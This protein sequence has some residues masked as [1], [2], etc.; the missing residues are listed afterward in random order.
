MLPDAD[1]FT[2]PPIP[3]QVTSLDGQHIDTSGAIW[4]IREAPEGGRLYPLNWS[5]LTSLQ[6]DG[7]SIYSPRAQHL[8]KLYLADGITRLKGGTVTGYFYTFSAFGRWLVTLNEKKWT[9][10]E[11][12]AYDESLARRYLDWC[13]QTYA[14]QGENASSLRTFIKWGVAR[15]YPDFT[16]EQYRVLRDMPIVSGT[17][18]HHT[19]FRHVTRGVLSSAEKQ[20]IIQALMAEKGRVHDRII[21]MLH[22]ELGLNPAASVRLL[23]QD[24][25]CVETAQGTLYQLDVPR[26]KKGTAHRE[27]K[28]RSISQRLGQLLVE[29]QE[30]EPGDRLLHWLGDKDPQRSI[31]YR[32]KY[33]VKSVSLISPR[34]HKLLKLMPRRFR[35][36]LATHLAEEGA[37]KQHIAE[38]L[39]HSNLNTVDV[40]VETTSRIIEP[41]ATATDAALK[42]LAHL[43]LGKVV[44]SVADTLT[45]QMI[46][47]T[48]THLPLPILN[49]G[50]VG[51]CGRDM[52]QDG[53]C[54]LFPPLSCYLCPSFIALR[55]GSHHELWTSLNT[56]ITTHPAGIDKRILRQLSDIQEAISEVLRQIEPGQGDS[57]E[58]ANGQ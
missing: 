7:R 24:F 2:L 29:L 58:V 28:R 49:T 52:R 21:V 17:S 34:T 35:Y 31:M 11:W 40:Y 22:L 1:E 13:I 36:T 27:T 8:I 48:V 45:S 44:D 18:G 25:K 50:H 19:C 37:S 3:Q 23:N 47:S 55:D 32:M 30:G 14:S 12:S 33:W 26:L 16:L 51:V 57:G 43:F 38:V 5:N 15:Q 20:L 39:D 42:P 46:D 10:F 53:L 56:F 9:H 4:H 6:I 54:Q 41:V